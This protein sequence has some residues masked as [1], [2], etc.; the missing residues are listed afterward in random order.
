MV[1]KY[2]LKCTFF[3]SL[4]ISTDLQDIGTIVVIRKLKRWRTYFKHK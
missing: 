1:E 4:G 3:L 2:Q